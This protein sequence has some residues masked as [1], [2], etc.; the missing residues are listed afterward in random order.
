MRSHINLVVTDG[1]WESFVANALDDDKQTAVH[2]WA[3]NDHLGFYI[4]Y[5]WKGS[6]RRY[7]P[8]FLVRLSQG[9]M[10]VLE[11]KG[12]PT[13]ESRAKKRA[14]ETWIAAV[15][16]YGSFGSWRSAEITELS[17]LEALLHSYAQ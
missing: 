5:L 14:L 4:S 7:L 15:N 13:E 11:V 16:A 10:L 6:R 8:D 9:E 1:A 17:E 2:S 12:E 3:K